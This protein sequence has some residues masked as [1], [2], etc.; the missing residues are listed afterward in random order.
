MIETRPVETQSQPGTQTGDTACG[1]CPLIYTHWVPSN[2]TGNTC[3]EHAATPLPPPLPPPHRRCPQLNKLQDCPNFPTGLFVSFLWWQIPEIVFF[4]FSVCVVHIGRY[5]CM[6]GHTWVCVHL[7]IWACM[8]RSEVNVGDF[9]VP[10]PPQS[11][12][13]SQSNPELTDLLSV[14]TQLLGDT[15]PLFL[16]FS[17]RTCKFQISVWHA[18]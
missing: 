15:L 10:S 9:S 18:L 8:W 17:G 3:V 14:A 1:K 12:Q 13:V 7:C 4:H 6:R 11:R 5:T 16:P 2:I